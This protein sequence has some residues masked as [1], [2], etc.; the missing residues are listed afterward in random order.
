MIQGSWKK[1]FI[2]AAVLLVASII[3]GGSLWQQLNA[4]N[5]QLNETTAQLEATNRQLDDIKAQL[6]SLKPE[7][8]LKAEQEQML[9]DYANLREQINLRLGIRED[10]QRFITPDDPEIW[11]KV[12]EITGGYSPDTVELWRDYGCLFRWIVQNIEYSADSP[13]PLLPESINGTLEWRKDFWRMPVETMKDGIGDC[14]DTA[15]LLA[16]MLLNYNQRRSTVW[17]LG[18]QTFGSTPKG[19]VAVALPIE[20]HQLTIFDP[21]ARYYTPFPHVGGIGTQEVSLAIDDWVTHLKDEMPG[22]Q[23][24][25]VFSEDF[26]QEFTNT[27]EFIDW[28]N[29]LLP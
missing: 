15:V 7:M 10:G 16:S 8:E 20:N 23:I 6:D 22:A 18:I 29:E 9:N 11:A 2:A 26:Y 1:L 27:Q 17:I 14:E 24:Y 19:H 21:S 4:T 3:L 12:L 28:V 5:R 25:A 13:S